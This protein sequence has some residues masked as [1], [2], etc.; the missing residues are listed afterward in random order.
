MRISEI[1][2]QVGRGEYHVDAHA[3]ADAIVRRLLQEQK[4]S[5]SAKRSHEECS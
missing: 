2:E 4:L 3:V 1:Q 5:G